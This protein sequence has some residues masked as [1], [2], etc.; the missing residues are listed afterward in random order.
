MDVKVVCGCGQKYVFDVEPVNGRMP[1]KVACPS[2]GADGTEA[3]N[4]VLAQY[5]PNRPAPIPVVL[6]AQPARA[7][8]APVTPP[9]LAAA[10]PPPPL[11]LAPRPIVPLKSPA[12]ASK[13][14][15]YHYLWI[16]LPLVLV[17][18]GGCLGGACG[19]AACVINRTVFQKTSNPVLKYVWTSVISAATFVIWI[20][21][22]ALLLGML[23][24]LVGR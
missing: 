9:P 24:G 4:N 16:G 23:H 3:A 10:L 5:F 17:M 13:L 18:T 19:G 12:P 14:M 8:V 6:S 11:P 1:I 7:P 21:V 20:I 15:W 2:C 22:A